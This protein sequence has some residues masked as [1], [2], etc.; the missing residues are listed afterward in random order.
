ME[1]EFSDRD[2][3]RLERLAYNDAVGDAYDNKAYKRLLKSGMTEEQIDGALAGGQFNPDNYIARVAERGALG[4]AKAAQMA[5]ELATTQNLAT[6][7]ELQPMMQTRASDELA[8]GYGTMQDQISMM[9][10]GVDPNSGAFQAAAADFLAQR[11]EATQR[12]AMDID[13]NSAA[14]RMNIVNMGR[15]YDLTLLNN[16]G[17][18]VEMLRALEKQE[19]MIADMQRGAVYGS[20]TAMIGRTFTGSNAGAL[21]FSNS[22]WTSFQRFMTGMSQVM[23]MGGSEAAGGGGSTSQG[24]DLTHDIPG[25]P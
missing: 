14:Q 15:E 25:A 1:N 22:A 19:D 20:P 13:M 24:G 17:Q 23:S 8:R 2:T 7:D 12:A 4:G 21:S 10:S 9:G 18:T 16:I 11:G 5:N 6:L 3:K